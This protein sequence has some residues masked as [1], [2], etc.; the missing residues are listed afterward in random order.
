MGGIFFDLDG[1]LLDPSEGFIFSLSHAFERCGLAV[2]TADALRGAIGPPADEWSAHF[3][4]DTLPSRSLPELVR[5]Y[6]AHYESVGIFKQ[7]LYPGILEGLK[8]LRA[9]GFTLAVATSKPQKQAELALAHFKFSNFFEGRIFGRDLSQPGDKTTVL[10]RAI[11]STGCLPSESI[12][13][14]DREFD[15]RAARTLG[16]WSISVLYGFGTAAELQASGPDFICEN[17]IQVV[18]T[19]RL[20]NSRRGS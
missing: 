14:G 11:N 19:I 3:G 1:T 18:A 12:M 7:T 4:E 2:P 8:S 16:L 5:T 17:P 13:I 20:L 9:E 10:S 6:R 15:C